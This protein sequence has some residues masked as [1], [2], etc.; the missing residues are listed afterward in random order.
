MNFPQTIYDVAFIN[1][2]QKTEV[3]LQTL[4]EDTLDFLENLA[5]ASLVGREFMRLLGDGDGEKRLARLLAAT[6][7]AGDPEGFFAELLEQLGSANAYNREP[8][9]MNDVQLPYLLLVSLLEK[10]IPGNKFISVTEVPQLEK[11][12][13]IRVPEKERGDLQ[14]VM[15]QYPVR[16]SSHTIRQMTVSRNVAYQYLPFVQELDPVGLVNTWI[17]QF[18]QG[19]LERMYQN[20][21]IFVLNMTCPVYC[22]FCFRKHKESRDQTNPTP[23]DV[24]KAVDYIRESP[25]IKEIVLTGGDPFLEKS[26]LTSAI[27]GL[28]EIPHVRTLRLATRSIAYYP[29]FFHANDSAWL[30]YLKMKHLELEQ[31]DKRLE[32]AT[33]F[34]HPDEISPDSLDIICDLVKNGIPVYVQTPF[35]NDCNDRGPELVKLFSLLRGAGAEIH[36]IYMP[37][38][39]IHGNSVYWAPLSKG[40]QVGSFLRGHLS[41]RAMPSM[42]T[43]T[44][45]GKIDWHSSGWAVEKDSQGENFIWLRTPYTPDFFKNFAPFASRQDVVRINAEGTLDARFM[46]KIGDETLFL[47]SRGAQPAKQETFDEKALQDIQALALQD[48]RDLQSIVPT[49]SSSLH[50]IHATRVELNCEAGGQDIGYVKDNSNITD[51]VLSAGKDAVECLHEMGEVISELQAVHHVNAARLRSLQFNYAPEKYTRAVIDKLGSL[52]RLSIVNPLRLEIETQFLHSGEFRPGHAKL[53]RKL[54]QKGITVYN[55]TPLLAKINNTPEE[56]HRIAYNC[57]DMGLEFQH[58]YVAGLR[59]Q[60]SWSREHPIDT[61]NVID[62]A[63]LVRREGSGRE[64]PRYIIRTPLGEVDFGMSSRIFRRNGNL[65][66]KLLPYD[67][68]YYRSLAPDFSWPAEVEVD[69]D[70]HPLVAVSGLKTTGDFFTY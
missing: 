2:K 32:I 56:I 9:M 55:C 24:Q 12:T 51:V 33:H 19:L 69:Q 3:S 57:R 50:R 42:C 14:E 11:L 15:E 70:G 48:Q 18:H 21:V 25:T 44:A 59:V 20:R 10:I 54:R 1:S 31:K 28:M 7:Y 60:N 40:L 63:T 52:N 26:N 8:I 49:G 61:G 23:E 17:G 4:A 53:M 37:C 45:I 65:M 58:V 34:I 68:E 27:D 6:G 64:I 62:I 36:Y 41:D 29:Q 43:A 35:L 5:E 13:N 38:S 39:P 46:A 47:G 30:N 66:V 67:L 16:L 22:R